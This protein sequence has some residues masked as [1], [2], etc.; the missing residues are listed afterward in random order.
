MTSKEQM[1]TPEE[2]HRKS[3]DMWERARFAPPPEP[4]LHPMEPTCI[5]MVEMRDGVKLYTEVFLPNHDAERPYPVILLR[6]P[7]PYSKPSL[8]GKEH[9]SPLVESDFALVFQLVRGQGDSEGRFRFFF[10][11]AEDGFDAIAWIMKQPWC[12]AN[13]GM[14]GASYL[15]ATQLY[16]AR[17]KPP[18][19][20]CIMPTAFVGSYTR[21]FPYHWG[22]PMK[23]AY[24]QWHEVADVESWDALDMPYGDNRAAEHP[25]WG[26]AV[27]K[28]PF[29]DSADEVLSGDKLMSFKETMAHPMDD[30]FW[31][32]IRFTDEDL[33]NFD[34]PI[35]IT[36]GWYDFTIGPTEFFQR[37]ERL[38]SA[39]EDRFL[40]VGPWNHYQTNKNAEPGEN[41]G[42][43]IL[44][45]NGGLDLVALKLAFFS[46]YL[47]GDRETPV[48]EDRVKVFITGANEWR[49]YPTL[50]APGTTDLEFYLH[51]NGSAHSYP[52]DGFL[53]RR[54]PVDEP[55][56][57]FNYDPSVPP[58]FPVSTSMDRRQTE[59]RSD[60]LTYTTSPFDRPLT[61]L[62]DMKLIL[63]AASDAL[64]TD[65]FVALT[66]VTTDGVSRSFHYAPL[67]FRARYRESLQE[68]TFLT[69]NR[70]ERF[71][72]PLGPA[73]HQIAVGN[74]LRLLVF[75]ASFP[76]YAC[77]SNMGRVEA[78]E[79]ETRAA[80]QS[81][82]HDTDRPSRLVLP[83]VERNSQ[84]A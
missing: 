55:V 62:G 51:S 33:A 25:K 70:P 49:D 24:M 81:I 39:V 52:S 79:T 82:Y 83:V 30:E 45:D 48:L 13:V 43:R 4:P 36:D 67:G 16:A 50:P 31:R 35:F 40:L 1:L 54:R 58:N 8:K 6:S 71:R 18:G 10:N 69:P 2:R 37:M 38:N 44:P 9:L 7:Y 56:D 19:L 11:E 17:E 5:D 60:V 22:V 21:S 41:D 73:G 29:I 26:P 34:I 20:K 47:K 78:Y 74:C 14:T 27:R 77:N 84:G 76:E 63:Y 3:L 42:D 59:V 66:E 32:P 80:T 68:E 28:R 72:I 57:V 12:N 64:D 61:I 15:G 75:S 65:W 53:D 46:R 23:A